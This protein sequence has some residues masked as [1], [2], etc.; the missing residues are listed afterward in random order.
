MSDLSKF[1]FW[2]KEGSATQEESHSM[3]CTSDQGGS[4]EGG[5][6]D[7]STDSSGDGD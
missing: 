2:Q 4:Q 5:G 6:M 7:C 1:R 3:A